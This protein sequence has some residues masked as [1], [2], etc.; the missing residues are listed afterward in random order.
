MH[1]SAPVF[2]TSHNVAGAATHVT[3][4]TPL[5]D[6][7][8]H[9]VSEYYFEV[10]LNELER[11]QEEEGSSIEMEYSV[12]AVSMHALRAFNVDNEMVFRLAS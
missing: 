1:S 3:D 4:P 9:E 5:T 7:E 12:S 2:A 6:S 11:L 8:Y 10:L